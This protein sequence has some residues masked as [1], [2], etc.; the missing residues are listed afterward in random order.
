M[1]PTRR[2]LFGALAAPLLALRPAA[3]DDGE[4]LGRLAAAYPDHIA[5][6]EG[7]DLVW[8]D[9]TRMATGAGAPERPFEV[10]LRDATLAD[11]MRQAYPAGPPAGPPPRNHSPGRLRNT[12]FFV[13]MYGDC[14]HGGAQGRHRTVTWMP[15]TRPQALPVTTVNDVATR[16]ERVV[17]DLEGLPDRLKAYLV[18]SAGT[19]NCRTVADTGLLS[20]HAHAAAIDLAVAHSD[21]W[22]WARARGDIPYRNRIPYA[23]AEVF[24]AH[25]FIWGGKWYH[26]DT[27]HFEY[28]PELI[29]GS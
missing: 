6:R 11:Q 28:R 25:R 21:Y 16:L 4:R 19:F 27:M 26:Y 20:M 24:E 10:M 13:K 17:A 2:I 14:R 5:R 1:G 8:R 7:A 22:S 18:P 15:K 9:G 23:I 12:A 3:A 29:G